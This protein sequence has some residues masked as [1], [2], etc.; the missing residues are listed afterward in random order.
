VFQRLLRV[1]SQSSE[2]AERSVERDGQ[3]RPPVK[4]A[5]NS[6]M[7]VPLAMISDG[8]TSVLKKSQAKKFRSAEEGVYNL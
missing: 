1:D 6:K 4:R 5:Q 8:F 7:T 3:I 2:V